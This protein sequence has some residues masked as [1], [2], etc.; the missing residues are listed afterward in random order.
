MQK[1]QVKIDNCGDRLD[2]FLAKNGLGF[3]LAQKM[4]R[5]NKITVNGLKQFGNWRVKEG[6]VV[7][8]ADNLTIKGSPKKR[9]SVSPEKLKLIKNCIIYQDEN[10]LAFDK[11]SGIAVQSGNKS[12]FSID[13]ALPFL[14]LDKQET[15]RL[16]HRLDRETSGV[17]LLARNRKSATILSEGFRDKT[18]NKTYVA[19]VK[20]VPSKKSGTIDLPL[21]QQN[22][23]KGKRV[24]VSKQEGKEA[25][26][27]YEVLQDFGSHSLLRLKP[28]TGRMH[29]LRVH[30]REIGHFI[31]GDDKYGG[32]VDST[33]QLVKEAAGRLCLHS[34]AVEINDF[35][36]KNL[37][38]ET[39]R[40]GFWNS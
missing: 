32:K 9:G 6:D 12:D 24:F 8:I 37:V 19:M 25:I 1:L 38:I 29:Q 27:K 26:S 30:C 7:N 23:G 35:F 15:P 40:A 39:A 10:L 3:A 36:G 11:P 4:L 28:I 14:K 20:G 31:I 5:S 34:L 33:N 21:A 16:V 18:I 17:L 22:L 2:K 13:A